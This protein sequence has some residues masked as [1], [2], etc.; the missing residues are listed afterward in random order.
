MKNL[1]L[2]VICIFVLGLS[3]GRTQTQSIYRAV[4]DS[5]ITSIV[6][7]INSDSVRYV[8]QSLQDFQT[9]FLLAPNRF[10]VADW[11]E[12]RFYEIGI[13][14][15]ERDSFMCNT[16][17]STDTTTLQINIIATITGTTRPDEVYIIGG[18]YDSFAYGS[19]LTNA[20]GA[21]DNGSGS[22]AALEFARVL[23]ESGY[24]PEATIKLITFAAE[25]L[26]L[27]GDAGCEHYAQQA[28]DDSMDI[29]LMINCDMI[30]HTL[31]TVEN[32]KVRINYYSGSVSM[33]DLAMDATEQF[34]LITPLI[35]SLNQYSDS[36]PFYEQ[37]FPAVYFEEDDFSPYYHTTNDIISN[38]NM[39]YCREVIKSAG[40]TLL[41][42]MLQN[43]P[44]DVEDYIN[45]P[46]L[47]NLYQN[48]PNPFNPST[49]INYSVP[50]TSNVVI[51]VFDILGNEIETLVNEE[52]AI[53]TYEI[54]WYAENLPSGIYFYRL[55]AGSFIET[56][57]MILMK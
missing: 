13:T 29:Q 53:G 23:I 6:S 40:A 46:T 49:K 41:K 18:H 33:R 8:I 54:N 48:Y 11:I 28:K 10:S 30:S 42:C 39:D 55:Q 1:F 36:Y 38:Y 15:V 52:K 26:M 34:S 21:D 43:S 24:Q 37:G 17:Y 19:P 27:F 47:A 22:S 12:N 51:K 3:N 2:T 9:R 57:K 5:V 35:G 25:E 16:S 44:T 56:K 14:N 50:Q 20:P 32:S 7:H 45:L 4:D 31:Q